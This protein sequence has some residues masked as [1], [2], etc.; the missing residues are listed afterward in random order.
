MHAVQKIERRLVEHD[1]ITTTAVEAITIE[2]GKVMAWRA[3]APE[4]AAPDEPASSRRRR[5]FQQDG[6]RSAKCPV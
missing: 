1:P 6:K 5:D 4:G 2:L 3:A